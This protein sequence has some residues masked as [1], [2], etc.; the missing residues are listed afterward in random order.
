MKNV[1]FIT[2]SAL[3][4][5]LACCYS[6]EAQKNRVTCTGQVRELL[7]I[8]TGLA[9]FEDRVL[10]LTIDSQ[11]SADEEEHH[12]GSAKNSGA[13]GPRGLEVSATEGNLALITL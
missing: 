8:L 7:D 12:V 6:A 5:L 4:C 3:L 1:M 9:S 13:G 10:R 2:T 11:L